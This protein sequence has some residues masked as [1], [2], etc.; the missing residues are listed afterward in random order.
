VTVLAC[1]WPVMAVLAAVAL[2]S[3]ARG[4]SGIY[5]LPALIALAIVAL[6]ALVTP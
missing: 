4:R 6:A 3:C 5:I 1:L 2:V